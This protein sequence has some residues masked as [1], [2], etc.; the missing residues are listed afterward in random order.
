MSKK[1]SSSPSSH[2]NTKP[3]NRS[4]ELDEKGVKLRT[5]EDVYHKLLWQSS[6][7]FSAPTFVTEVEEGAGAR[8]EQE[9][10][11]H[12]HHHYHQHHQ[13]HQG[14]RE[15]QPFDIAKVNAARVMIGYEDRMVGMVETPLLEWK[16][17]PIGDIPWH[18]VWYFR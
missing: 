4:S 7:T 1:L 11:L 12:H 9:G 5:S 6:T 10:N 14:D 16:P 13:H 17:I 8:E 2:H 15:D 18:R 3:N